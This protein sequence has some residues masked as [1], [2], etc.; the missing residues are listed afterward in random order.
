MGRAYG[1]D[2]GNRD[3]DAIE[4]GMS[5]RAGARHFSV[6]ISTAGFWHC[7]WRRTGRYEAQRQGGRTGSVLDPHKAFIMGLIEGQADI[8]LA[9]M[10]DAL[11]NQ[12][13]LGVDPSTICYFLKRHG[14]TYKKRQR[15]PASK[16]GQMC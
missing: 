2:L 5:T 13:D 14:V 9:E 15:R 7:A 6:G 11:R 1:I 8:T 12:H 16:R 4:D 3:L 10:A